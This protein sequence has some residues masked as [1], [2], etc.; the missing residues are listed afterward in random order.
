MN[1]LY[2][3][4][5]VSFIAGGLLITLLTLLAERTSSKVSGIVLSF[6]STIA[7]GYFFLG[8][9]LSS[10]KVA[11]IAPTTMVA[12]G[13]IVPFAGVY[14]RTAKAISAYTNNKISQIALS[15]IAS[16][17]VWL[18]IVTVIG[19]VSSPLIGLAGYLALAFIGTKLIPKSTSS[20]V[21]IKKYTVGQKTG[22]AIF[23]GCIIAL[24][25]LLGKTAGATW[26]GVFSVFP[27]ALT[28]ALVVIHWHYDT[29][30]LSAMVQKVAI[31]SLSLLAYAIT[32][33]LIFSKAG[34]VYG[35]L[36][37]YIVSL[38]VT[39]ILIRVAK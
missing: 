3:Q 12:I 20:P 1:T 34:F 37:S 24:V 30:K 13:T 18:A 23:I 4:V 9:T 38:G 14:V 22:R 33:T 2:I 27:A 21:V 10:E 7:L 32:A 8:W 28:S 19:K 35:T 36:V 25:V 16:T 6:P 29:E 26:G 11:M 39:L 31:G 17:T 15:L 5:A